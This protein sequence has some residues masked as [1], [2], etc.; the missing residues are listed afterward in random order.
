MRTKIYQI[1][2]VIVQVFNK[3]HIPLNPQSS[4]YISLFTTAVSRKSLTSDGAKWTL[5]YSG[6][7]TNQDESGSEM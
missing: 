5:E 4:K 3:D 6:Y 7:E 1:H 2:Q